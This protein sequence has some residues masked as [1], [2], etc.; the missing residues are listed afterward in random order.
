MQTIQQSNDSATK[1]THN[2]TVPLGHRVHPSK[3]QKPN[4]QAN[5][6]LSSNATLTQNTFNEMSAQGAQVHMANTH[7]TEPA[8]DT[9]DPFAPLG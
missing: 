6:N 3:V 7:V 2:T 5:L 1:R 8:M 9:S 4:P